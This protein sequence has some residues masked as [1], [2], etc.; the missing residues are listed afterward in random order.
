[1]KRRT[2]FLGAIAGILAIGDAIFVFLRLGES[3]ELAR[4]QWIANMP[5]LEEAQVAKP[6]LLRSSEHVDPRVHSWFAVEEEPLFTFPKLASEC[7]IGSYLIVFG[8]AFWPENF[9]FGEL[10]D[11]QVACLSKKLPAGHRVSKL[12]KPLSTSEIKTPVF[13]L[14]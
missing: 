12:S 1:M 13:N 4:Y 6:E 5:E 2:A 10:E 7:K 9:Y 3:P 11:G 14:G 8:D